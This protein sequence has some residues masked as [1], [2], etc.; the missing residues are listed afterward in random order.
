MPNIRTQL[1]PEK[2]KESISVLNNIINACMACSKDPDASWA[3]ACRKNSLDPLA[4]RRVILALE[5]CA[6]I[7]MPLKDMDLDGLHNGYERFYQAVFGDQ[8]L[9]DASLP[10]DYKESVL[11][12]V[13]HTG[14]TD[15]EIFILAH[16]FGIDGCE[17]P[18]TLQETAR[19]LSI[20]QNRVHE[21]QSR[22]IC[23]CL[24]EPRAM[25]LKN[26]IT[27][28]NAMK[29]QAKGLIAGHLKKARD[30]YEVRMEEKEARYKGRMAAVKAGLSTQAPQD[31][32]LEELH[33]QLKSQPVSVLGVSARIISALHRNRITDLAGLIGH[34]RGYFIGLRQMGQKSAD[35]VFTKLDAYI[36]DC[37]GVSAD[38][39]RKMLA[40]T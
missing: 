37:Y 2:L 19:Q 28:Y 16:R 8:V 13:K 38:G 6:D 10:F 31:P 29:E 4:A 7:S 24:D 12:V 3:M 35:E 15:R 21:I 27:E 22:L 17:M 5:K 40:D 30:R 32:V 26:G 25:I 14:F 11:Y 33:S 20:C 39:L 23:R 34:D 18:E 36:Q 1:T 9:Q